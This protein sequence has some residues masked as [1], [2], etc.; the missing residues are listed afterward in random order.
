MDVRH[1][2]HIAVKNIILS[3]VLK[4]SHSEWTLFCENCIVKVKFYVRTSRILYGRLDDY[5]WTW[6]LRTGVTLLL[7]IFIS[8]LIFCVC[9]YSFKKR[10]RN[11]CDVQDN[12]FY[13]NK[14]DG[15]TSNCSWCRYFLLQILKLLFSVTKNDQLFFFKLFSFPI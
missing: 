7:V 6:G 3:N 8:F 5:I 1:Q 2:F 14:I 12:I 11:V 9:L 10:N 4:F 13:R 15:V